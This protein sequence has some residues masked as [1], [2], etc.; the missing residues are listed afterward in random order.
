LI[1]LGANI[2]IPVTQ[3]SN[4]EVNAFTHFLT[5]NQCLIFNSDIFQPA[6]ILDFHCSA[7]IVFFFKIVSKFNPL[8]Q[9]SFN[10]NELFINISLDDFFKSFLMLFFQ[11]QVIDAALLL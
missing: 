11:S 4:L 6:E 1:P 9:S 8:L 5:F 2:S 3:I 10:K 7:I